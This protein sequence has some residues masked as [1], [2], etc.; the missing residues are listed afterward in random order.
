MDLCLFNWVGVD[1]VFRVGAQG[2][3]ADL[4]TKC[5]EDTLTTFQTG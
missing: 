4:Y 2:Q 5:E 1:E 3:F